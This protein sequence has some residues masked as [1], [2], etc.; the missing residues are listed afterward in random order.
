[1][2]NQKDILLGNITVDDPDGNQTH[3]C[4]LSNGI[5]KECFEIIRRGDVQMLYLIKELDFEQ[6]SVKRFQI[7]CREVGP[8]SAY[9]L[10]KQ[11][12][13]NVL[14]KKFSLFFYSFRFFTTFQIVKINIKLY[15]FSRA[16]RLAVLE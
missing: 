16:F 13:L 1:M 11:F 5:E 4:A 3:L 8:V 12:D 6:E 7:N 9:S 2:E 10:T 15:G 14:G